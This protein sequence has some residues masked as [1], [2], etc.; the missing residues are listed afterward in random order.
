MTVETF[1]I[2]CALAYGL[3]IGSFANVCIYRLPRGE[4][5]VSPRSRCPSCGAAIAAHD[6]VPVVSWLL[7]GARCRTCKAPIPLRYPAIELLVGLL[8]AAN[9]G[10]HGPGLAAL[11]GCVLGAAAVI[12]AVTDFEY[13]VLP[14]QVT[15]PVLA[16]GLLLALARDLV[17]RP[18]SWL[19]GAL[20]GAVAG[21][22]LGALLLLA[23]RWAYWRLRHVEGMGAGD[24]T[25]IAMAGAF[26]GPAGV[27]LVLFVASAAGAL[28]GGAAEAARHA[29]WRLALRRVRSG[30]IR[31]RDLALRAGLLVGDDGTVLAASRRWL[32]LP[33]AAPEGSPLSSSGPVARP[34][35]A[36]VR[37]ARRRAARALGTD[38]PR[39]PVEEPDGLYFRML[40]VHAQRV[41]G[42][43]LVLVG[44]ADIPFGVF[45]AVG[46]LLV[47]AFGRDLV[48]AVLAGASTRGGPLP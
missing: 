41:E 35:L 11:A 1:A 9:V 28:V 21:A 32:G 25:M 43:L 14:D 24:V 17:Q 38:L 46:S 8:F 15:L 31:P 5:V 16:L 12:L 22:A 20:S 45:L 47:H 34:L 7:L 40:A 3:V 27:L 6:N 30:A 4:S 42:G 26:V 36:A 29:A 18:S 33:G 48:G 37:L 13:R 23:V 19:A 39:V 2:L 44:R 10:L